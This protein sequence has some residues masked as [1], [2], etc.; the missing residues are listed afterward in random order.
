MFIFVTTLYQTQEIQYS[1]ACRY[2]S[3]SFFSQHHPQPAA[4]P[5][6]TPPG[7][8]R[9]LAQMSPATNARPLPPMSGSPR[10]PRTRISDVSGHTRLVVQHHQ[11]PTQPLPLLSSPGPHAHGHHT[12]LGKCTEKCTG[13]LIRVQVY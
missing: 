2:L 4:G 7:Y 3:L 10:G 8:S 13:S 9:P 12:I 1:N 5:P 11:L 6:G